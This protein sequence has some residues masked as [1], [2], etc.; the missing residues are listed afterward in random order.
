MNY[1]LFFIIL[2]V[3]LVIDI[4]WLKLLEKFWMKIIPEIQGSPMRVRTISAF[5]VYL[6]LAFGI[7]V[8]VYHPER[9]SK[10]ERAFLLGLVIY[11][12]FDATNYALFDKYPLWMAMV[13]GLWGGVLC[14][15][16][17]Y[18]IDKLLKK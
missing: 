5:V 4:T 14:L 12:V 8:F 2:V 16:V 13:D 10:L 9:F 17:A 7:W 3:L 18:S 6:L 11:G 1:K 15:L